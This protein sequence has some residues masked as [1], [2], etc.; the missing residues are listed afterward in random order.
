MRAE[1]KAEWQR[2]ERVLK[3]FGL[4]VDPLPGVPDAELDAWER[5][6]GLSLDRDLRDL[7]RFTR[8]SRSS[9]PWL[10]VR[11]DELA[12]LTLMDPKESLEFAGVQPLAVEEEDRIEWQGRRLNSDPRIAPF[13][14]HPKWLPFAEFNGLGTALMLDGAPGSSGTA[15]QLIAF[16][17]DPDSLW[18]QA[19]S[20]L[21]LF[22]RSN[23]LY[24]EHG[25][26]LL[27]DEEEDDAGEQED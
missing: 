27:E 18:W 14:R 13:L 2:L 6:F 11:T 19:A 8:G 21:E 26:M 22:A 25:T 24:A 1:L 4:P 23:A 12:L 15:G 16:Q 17:H 3:G 20:F 10:C 5:A 7:Y 9:T